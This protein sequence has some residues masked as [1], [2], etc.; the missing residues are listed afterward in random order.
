M[1]G[2]LDQSSQPTL[3]GK[4]DRHLVCAL[5]HIPTATTVLILWFYVRLKSLVSDL[6][7]RQRC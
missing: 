3:K 5:V 2:V 4:V 1:R 7:S 6:V